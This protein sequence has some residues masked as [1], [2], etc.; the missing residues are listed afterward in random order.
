MKKDD[1]NLNAMSLAFRK[2]VEEGTQKDKDAIKAAM[3][4][5]KRMI[6]SAPKEGKIPRDE[7]QK[8]VKLVSKKNEG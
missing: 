7:I 4:S 5:E 8:A 3:F 1:K 6:Q 2:A